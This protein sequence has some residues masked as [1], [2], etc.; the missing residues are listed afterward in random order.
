MFSDGLYGVV[1][2]EEE[3]VKIFGVGASMEEF[4]YAFVTR[5]LFL[6]WRLSISLS[7]CINLLAMKVNFQMLTSLPNFKKR[8][9]SFKLK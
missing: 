8:F 1:E 5:K 6:F 4:S 9:L 3:D 2:I 7:K